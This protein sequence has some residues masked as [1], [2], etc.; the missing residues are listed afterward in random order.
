MSW[1]RLIRFIPSSGPSGPL[2]GEP[3]DAALDVGLA[4]LADPGSIAAAIFSGSSVLSPGER[5]GEIRNV[6][7]LLS[8]LAQS[9]VGTIRCIGINY[10]RHA[11]EVKME[12]PKQ[13]VLFMKP[14]TSLNDPYP[15]KVPIPHQFAADD[16]CDYESE[17]AVVIGKEAKNVT[18]AD[19]ME[20]CLGLTAS[21][22]VSQRVAQFAQSQWCF[23]KSFDGA[24]PI[25]PAL[26]NVKDI[27]DIASMKIKGILNGQVVQEGG[28]DDLIFSIPKIVSF[29]S[30]G[31]TLKPGTLILTGTPFGVGWTRSPRLT[32][33]DN[34]EVRVEV[35]SGVGTL[36]NRFV[37][38]E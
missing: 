4:S 21:N 18:E 24:C 28:L 6:S 1:K 19:A 15:A 37:V 25:G 34:D 14:E 5:T 36:I 9:E 8:P 22:D 16:A 23:S 7:R 13:P 26:V 12:I 38:E 11:E 27:E 30:Q 31:T 10:L 20:Y 3:V 32:L 35:S 29:L 17:V 2:I 33:K